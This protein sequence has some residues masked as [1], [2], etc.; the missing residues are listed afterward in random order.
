MKALFATSLA[1]LLVLSL[2]ASPFAPAASAEGEREIPIV[3]EEEAGEAAYAGKKAQIVTDA[4]VAAPVAKKKADAK[5]KPAEAK[6]KP[7]DVPGEAKKLR[8]GE[9][10]DKLV[11]TFVKYRPDAEIDP[12][13]HDAK[14][15][16]YDAARAD[17][18]SSAITS[19]KKLRLEARALKGKDEEKFDRKVRDVRALEE[20]ILAEFGTGRQAAKADA[21]ETGAEGADLSPAKKEA[22]PGIEPKTAEAK[23]ILERSRVPDPEETKG[24]KETKARVTNA[25]DEEEDR[26]AARDESE[27][28]LEK[29]R[30]EREGA[31]YMPAKLRLRPARVL[32]NRVDPGAEQRGVFVLRNAGRT[33]FEGAIVAIED[34][35]S[36]SPPTV[37]IEPN[38]EIEIDVQITAPDKKNTR[39]EGS[40][41]IRAVGESSRRIP[42]VVRTARK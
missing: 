30:K 15:P 26:A 42:V 22:V 33:P 35:I 4:G 18:L 24:G 39:Y 25:D 19:W 16:G 28:R 20:R 9:S 37:F 10:V 27:R 23:R 8:S 5:A 41:E 6:V 12:S 13:F 2:F 21:A 7:A 38:A 40:V 34:W 31:K 32:F 14:A 11:K 1:T 17:E 36:V 29:V 3:V